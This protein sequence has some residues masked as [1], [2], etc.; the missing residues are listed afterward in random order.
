MNFCLTSIAP[1]SVR[2]RVLGGLTTSFFLGQFL[3]PLAS[4]PLNKAVGLKLTYGYAGAVMAV[5]A[6][7][8]FVFLT[9]SWNG[10]RRDR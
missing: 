10:L 3:S 5:L 9:S 6:A 2:G 7:I 4:Q 1:G 8:A